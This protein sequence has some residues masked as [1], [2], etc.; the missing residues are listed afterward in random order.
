[1]AQPLKIARNA[2][3]TLNK[4]FDLCLGVFIFRL[5]CNRQPVFKF[6][7]FHRWFMN[8]VR[9]RIPTIAPV[10]LFRFKAESWPVATTRRLSGTASLASS[11]KLVAYGDP[12]SCIELIDGFQKPSHKFKSKWKYQPSVSDVLECEIYGHRALCKAETI[13]ESG[14]V[15]MD[16]HRVQVVGRR[17][18]S[19]FGDVD[20]FMRLFA[21]K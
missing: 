21:I 12:P 11:S 6:F 14:K 18:K 5:F 8:G 3:I 16:S 7:V 20:V 15:F 4:L 13:L 10:F 19:R 17:I 1:M 2:A 9:I